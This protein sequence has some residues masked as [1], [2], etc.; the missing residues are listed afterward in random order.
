MCT[1]QSKKIIRQ[2]TS[3]DRNAGERGEK[4]Y[5]QKKRKI[6]KAHTHEV[7]VLFFVTGHEQ[8]V[9]GFSSRKH[10][11]QKKE[12]AGPVQNLV[13]L[14]FYWTERANQQ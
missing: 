8:H 3:V 9:Q 12:T 11:T 2:D 1:V 14:F 4:R 13:F 7:I 6:R 5:D 10:A